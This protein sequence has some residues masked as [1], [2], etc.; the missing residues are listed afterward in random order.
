[1]YKS[2]LTQ[3]PD[4]PSAC[5]AIPKR[6]DFDAELAEYEARESRW[7]RRHAWHLPF[8]ERVK[9]FEKRDQRWTRGQN[10][11]DAGRFRVDDQRLDEIIDAALNV[12]VALGR[13]QALCEG[14]LDHCDLRGVKEPLRDYCRD[15]DR[16]PVLVRRVEGGSE[17][18]D[19]ARSDLILSLLLELRGWRRLADGVGRHLR[20]QLNPHA[21]EHSDPRDERKRIAA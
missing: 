11:R 15:H 19:R 7:D 20:D 18:L 8:D 12:E 13:D 2:R 4:T 17:Y 5:D 10:L 3:V 6:F 9:V 14:D 16:R 1:M 21:I